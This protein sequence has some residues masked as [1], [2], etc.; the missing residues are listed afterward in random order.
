MKFDV[1]GAVLAVVVAPLV[2]V[3]NVIVTAFEIMFHKKAPVDRGKSIVVITGCDS[4]FG[5]MTSLKLAEMGFIVVAGCLTEEGVKRMRSTDVALAVQCDVTKQ[6]DIDTLTTVTEELAATKNA[7]LWAV[8][9]NAG[10]GVGGA[11]DWCPMSLIRKVME[12]N[13]FGVVMVAKAMIPMLKRNPGS[14]IINV[15]SL[16]GMFSGPNLGPYSASKHAVEGMAKAWRAEL[17]PWKIHVSNVNPGFMR[18]PIIQGGQ[19]KNM[20]FLK[21]EPRCMEVAGEYDLE[22]SNAALSKQMQDSAEDP[23]QV[24]DIIVDAITDETPTLWY[25]PG[26]QA[27]VM[28]HVDCACSG[29]MDL[30]SRMDATV[31]QPSAQAMARYRQ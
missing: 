24:R 16:A 11:I 25:M 23:C 27:S 6:A 12:V 21:D 28:R 7:K 9:N 19:D 18:T 3:L 4:G 15:S 5:E 31:A 1:R 13:F 2:F 30:Y 17:R 10:I 22:R 20:S 8:V 26:I 14:R 29:V